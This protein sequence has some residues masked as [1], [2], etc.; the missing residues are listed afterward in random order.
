MHRYH[1]RFGGI[2]TI[3]TLC[4]GRA[5]TAAHCL[6]A[7]D[8][9]PGTVIEAVGRRFVVVRRWSPFGTDLA[10]LRALTGNGRGEL[11]TRTF[12]RPGVDVTFWGHTGRRF[13]RRQATIVAV[14]A[15]TATARVHHARGVCGNDSGGPVFA[16]DVLAGIAVARTGAAVSARCSCQLVMVRTDSPSMRRRI[17]AAF[18]RRPVG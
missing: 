17:A 13:Q 4:D 1:R 16:G 3:V 15:T 8:G 10:V 11:A 5:F 12:L 18:E 6:A 2:G 7:V 9:R 14:T